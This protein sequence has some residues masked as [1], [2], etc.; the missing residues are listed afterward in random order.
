LRARLDELPS[1]P[2]LLFVGALRRVKGVYE[3]LEAYEQLSDPPPLVLLGTYEDDSPTAFPP[4]V[5]V[6]DDFPHDAVLEACERCLF[7]VMPS[8][9][10]EP[11]GTVVAEVM[12]RGRPVI[13]TRPGGH[14]DMIVHGETGLLVPRG[15]VPAL[16]QAMR[17]LLEDAELKARMG[18]AASVKAAEF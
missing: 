18:E 8:L 16:V 2:F 1:E 15:D 11:L 9:W 10:P 5:L 4:G 3:L 12:S 17:T 7:G 14:E 13:G 6:L